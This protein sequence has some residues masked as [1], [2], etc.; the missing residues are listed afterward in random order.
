MVIREMS[1]R[2]SVLITNDTLSRDLITHTLTH[3]HIYYVLEYMYVLLSCTY[4]CLY[5]Y[6][7][8][9]DMFVEA[10][11]EN[12]LLLPIFYPCTHPA[13]VNVVLI[14]TLNSSFYRVA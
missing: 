9:V 2:G 5:M 6:L 1:S 7:C 12:A 4:T 3:T 10:T 13:S 11:H 14:Y 8:V